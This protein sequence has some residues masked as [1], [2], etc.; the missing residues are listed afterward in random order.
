M[1]VDASAVPN[2]GPYGGSK[3]SITLRFGSD[4]YRVDRLHSNIPVGP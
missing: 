1:I 2:G 3:V 4:H